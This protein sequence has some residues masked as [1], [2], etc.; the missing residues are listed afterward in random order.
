M[1]MSASAVPFGLA[2]KRPRWRARQP[3]ALAGEV[4]LISV[5]SLSGKQRQTV[6]GRHEALRDAMLGQ[7]QEALES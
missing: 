6:V 3:D 1:I 7:R 4:R 2:E 5:A